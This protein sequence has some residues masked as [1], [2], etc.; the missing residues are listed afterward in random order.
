LVDDEPALLE[1][2]KEFLEDGGDQKVSVTTSATEALSTVRGRKFD[3]I[4]SDYQM[5]EMNGIALLRAL[6]S[7]DDHTPF[8][9]F[10]GKGREDVAIGALNNGANF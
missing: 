6:R 4:V 7:G 10:T 5:P 8:V 2:T 1:I 9:L 3:V